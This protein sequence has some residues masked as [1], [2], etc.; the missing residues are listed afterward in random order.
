MKNLVWNVMNY[1][2][3]KSDFEIFNIFHHGSF[4]VYVD[5]I[6]RKYKN[7][8]DKEEFAEKL[9]REL[10]YYFWSK[11]EWEVIINNV[12]GRIIV[13]PWIGNRNN[14]ELDVTDNKDF[15]WLGFYDYMNDRYK[16]KDGKIKIDVYDQVRY[17][18]DEFVDYCWNNK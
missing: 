8:K 15:D 10:S 12:N 9:R 3:N 6:F 4:K 1:N 11:A 2:I 17:R 18:W 7:S 14:L 5:D 13:T 16:N